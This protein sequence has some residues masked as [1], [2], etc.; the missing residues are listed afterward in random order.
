[1]T[2]RTD[3]Q[4]LEELQATKQQLAAREKALK[5]RLRN[6]SRKLDARRKII[7]GAVA[8]EHCKH[9]QE[10]ADWFFQVLKN[11]VKRPED[12]RLLDLPPLSE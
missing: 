3:E 1:M 7:A 9:D 4:R 10:W 5:A 2:R 6:K 8:L 12:R 11:E